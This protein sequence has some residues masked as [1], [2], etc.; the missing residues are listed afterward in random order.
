MYK[1]IILLTLISL[2]SMVALYAQLTVRK[3]QGSSGSPTVV[4]LSKI[5]TPDFFPSLIHL[6]Q[7]PL[8]AAA[9]GD[10]KTELNRLRALHEANIATTQHTVSNKTRSAANPV[11]WKDFAGN[12]ANSV[13]NDNDI[14]VSNA[15][16][17]LSAVN[18][19]LR[20][21]DDTGK[22]I[23][24]ISLSTIFTPVGN[25]NWISDPRVLYDPST[26]RFVLV[27]FS[28]SLSNTS[29]ILVAFTQTND[30][31]GAWNAYTL[32]GNMFNDS[33]W[34]DYPIIAL[35]DKD[36]F[37][38][39]NQVMDNVSWTIGFKQSVIWQI[40]K[41]SGYSGAPLQYTL[42]D[43][44]Q[45]NGINLRNICPAKYQSSTMGNNMYFLTVRNVAPSNDSLFVTEIT[46]SHASGNATMNMRL[47][48]TPVMYGFPPNA[49]QRKASNGL[50]QYLMTNDARVL[51]AIYEN[52]Y[53]HFG[54]NTLNPAHMNAG[55]MLGTIENISSANPVVKAQIFSTPTQEFGYP[56]MAYM[57]QGAN[58]HKVL[59]TFSHCYTDSF[60]GTSMIY[61][62][63][64]DQFSDV[65]GVKDGTSI[66]NVLADSNDRWGDYTNIQRV[67]NQS[68]RAYLAGSW[69]RLNI[70]NS[71]VAA[72]D[73][74]NWPA[75]TNTWSSTSEITVYPNPLVDDRFIIR[76]E[77]NETQ[78]LYFDLVDMNGRLIKTV[79]HTRVK[80][81][82]NEFSFYTGTMSSGTYILYIR[83]D[84]ASLY[85]QKLIVRQ[86]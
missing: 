86:Q 70:M 22:I 5:Q 53:V 13:P 55:V 23:N 18:S 47:L 2:Q 11:I 34:S 7:Q 17:V 41:Q 16:I 73:I 45:Y 58:D 14:A 85:S 15:G 54:L 59:Y 50:Q 1:R 80:K 79:L 35:S 29:T 8:P 44:M 38:T 65:I 3:T 30:P 75:A 67:Y 48:S 33:T 57:G 64:N 36:L 66:I 78:N 4:D 40:D 76:F 6:D 42:W 62:D 24:T 68:N 10:K 19:N 31:N 84:K 51:A 20:I 49:R 9:Y 56:S 74:V 63:H 71:W 60:P 81:G 28:G 26:D 39:F 21:Y 61:K 69:G 52:N 37:M 83:S 25:F 12:S 72:V 46:N 32:N 82:K 77:N 27:C 43:S